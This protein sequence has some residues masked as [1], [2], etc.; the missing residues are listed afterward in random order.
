VAKQASSNG[1]PGDAATQ[2][3]RL[4]PHECSAAEVG[5]DPTHGLESATWHVIRIG[6][7]EEHT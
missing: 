5:S 4:P 3:G 2:S 1:T 7:A 6:I